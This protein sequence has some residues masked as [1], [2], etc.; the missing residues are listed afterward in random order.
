MVDQY[1]PCLENSVFPVKMKKTRSGRLFLGCLFAF[2]FVCLFIFSWRA[3]DIACC[4]VVW[5]EGEATLCYWMLLVALWWKYR[6]TPLQKRKLKMDRIDCLWL[7]GI[8]TVKST[9]GAL[10]FI[11]KQNSFLFHLR[12]NSHLSSS[13]NSCFH[14]RHWLLKSEHKEKIV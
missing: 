9:D 13:S 10:L 4:L 14:R 7:N 1:H 6:E 8:C 5:Q 3:G 12:L 2:F 11:F